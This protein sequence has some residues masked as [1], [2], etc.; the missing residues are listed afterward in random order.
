[1]LDRDERDELE[2]LRLALEG[3]GDGVWEWEIDSERQYLSPR[4]HE[5]LGY[6]PGEFPDD[7]A[8][9]VAAIHPADWPRVRAAV[10]A[11][12]AEGRRYDVEFRLRTKS[13][14]WKWVRSRGR[15]VPGAGAHPRRIVGV[16][17]DIDERKQL[18]AALVHER[19]KLEALFVHMPSPAFVKDLEGRYT[20]VNPA[21]CRCFGHGAERWLGRRDAD[22]LPAED[23]GCLARLDAE[24]L[25]TGEAHAGPVSFSFEGR[26]REFQVVLF[27]L[28]D[29]SHATFALAGVATE[30]TELRET[31]RLA[32]LGRLLGDFAHELRS[33]LFALSANLDLLRLQTGDGGCPDLDA[34][35]SAVE[36]ESRRLIAMTESLIAYGAPTVPA[37]V[38]PLE[39]VLEGAISALAPRLAERG[40][41]VVRLP[42]PPLRVRMEPARLHLAFQRLLENASQ[43]APEGS[44]IC[45]SLRREAVPPPARAVVEIADRGPG[46]PPQALP[47]LF[48]PFFSLRR[49]GL[50]LGLATVRRIVEA[51][52]GRASLENR[53]DGG[54]LATVTLP[55]AR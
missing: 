41:R 29:A 11:H 19:A 15:V 27:P 18:E 34:S 21:L 43:H 53:H 8:S 17:T 3:S 37:D 30:V 26:S 35:L 40:Q 6:A 46:F 31:Q 13:A 25:R 12:F 23:A 7:I 47:C 36:A 52:G 14:A 20:Y 38:A 54:A 16:I 50:G 49:D 32:G 24:V 48:H 39:P 45:V 44:G 1:M 5:I 10:D 51:H 9:Y 2:R 42:G 55:V 4:W 28:R 33:P 22:L